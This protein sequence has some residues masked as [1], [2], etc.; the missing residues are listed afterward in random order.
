MSVLKDVGL[1]EGIKNFSTV[2]ELAFPRIS[3]AITAF[4][5]AFSGSSGG[6][7]SSLAAGATA[8]A[9]AISPLTLAIG[10]VT[11]ALGIGYAAYSIYRSSIDEAVN[12]AKKAG[13]EW[14]SNTTTLQEQV[15]RITELR[16]ALSSGTLTEQEAADAKNELLSIQESLSESYGKQVAGIDLING[17]LTEQIALLGKVSEKQ[18]E[19]FQNE[20]KKGIKEAEKQIEKKRHTYLGQ[21]YDNG[22]DESEA[23]KKTIKNLQDKYGKDA[24]GSKSIPSDQYGWTQELGTESLIRKR[25]GAIVTPFE[26]GDMVLDADATKNLWDMMNDPSGFINGTIDDGLS[27]P[28]SS[29]GVG[30][31]TVNNFDNITFDLPNVADSKQ[32][33]NE[34]I[35]DRKFEQLIRTMTVDRMSGK[36]S[37]SKY[38]F[39]K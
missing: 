19:Q 39:R 5:T 34:M 36:S 12:S 6:L 7:F 23:I 28:I 16:E 2:L 30:S 27:S 31:N 29:M 18:A 35:N 33:M 11:A 21:F 22:S 9:S 25:D 1:V 8:A 13:S 14:E 20:N 37:V 15:D 17:S 10:G 4:S 38:K 24:S 3:S 26:R 32:F